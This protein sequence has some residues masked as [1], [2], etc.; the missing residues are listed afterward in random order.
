M[1]I[2]KTYTPGE[3]KP[4]G[5]SLI[6]SEEE[7]GALSPAARS[8]LKAWRQGIALSPSEAQELIDKLISWIREQLAEGRAA[9]EQICSWVGEEEFTL[10]TE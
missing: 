9:Q 10:L 2:K 7:T 5:Y 1:I 4:W 6:L 3:A 8:Q